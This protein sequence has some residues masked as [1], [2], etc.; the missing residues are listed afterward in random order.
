MSAAQVSG[1]ATT[2]TLTYDPLGRLYE[3]SGAAGG[4]STT[5]FLYDGDALVAEYNDG[6]GAM[7][8]RYVHGVGGADRPY[9]WYTGSAVSASTRHHLFANHQGSISLI[10]NA[11]GFTV[12][13]INAYDDWGIPKGA[14][15]A[16]PA[17]DNIEIT[18]TRAYLPVY[19]WLTPFA[20]PLAPSSNRSAQP[21]RS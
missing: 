18:V 13:K 14:A 4:A 21:F 16:T 5:R 12:V 1:G 9:V 3:T 10:T 6:G 19:P 17:D 20:S 15:T 8:N 11:T 7:T 2:A